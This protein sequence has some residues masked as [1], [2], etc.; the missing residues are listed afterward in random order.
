MILIGA[1]PLYAHLARLRGAPLSP[2]RAAKYLPYSRIDKFLF[3]KDGN[4]DF[5]SGEKRLPSLGNRETKYP[6][7][8][9]VHTPFCTISTFI[10]R[11]SLW[12][13]YTRGLCLYGPE[14]SR[15]MNLFKPKL[16]IIILG[17]TSYVMLYTDVPI[18][19]NT[20]RVHETT[21]VENDLQHHAKILLVTY[22]V[23]MSLPRPPC[24]S[25]CH[26]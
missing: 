7:C 5:R 9:T 20:K 16:L 2:Q 24:R 18:R 23:V 1:I 6:G 19:L 14:K 22:L 3:W 4:L 26:I 12:L 17:F 13:H 10:S 21:I 11:S 15:S 8:I 25:S